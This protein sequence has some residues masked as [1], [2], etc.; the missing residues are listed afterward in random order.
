LSLTPPE[1]PFVLGAS[2]IGASHT[3]LGL[4]CQD[5]CA[6]EILASRHCLA[7]VC[8]GLGSAA[9]SDLGA[10]TAVQAALGAV[11]TRLA[12]A[13]PLI[14]IVSEAVT[15]ARAAL[16][17]LAA[18]EECPLR[19][20]ACTIL[21]LVATAEEIATAHIGDGAMVMLTGGG[22]E[23]ASA[24]GESEYANEVV[25]LTSPGWREALRTGARAVDVRGVALFSDGLQRIALCKTATG[26]EPHDGFLDPVFSYAAELGDLEEGTA[27][28]RGLLASPKLAAVS[29][30]DK[31]LVIGILGPLEPR[32]P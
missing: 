15:A 11:K 16:E 6:F 21:V 9:R 30:D 18:R 20:L 23:I 26:Y 29:E 1:A 31:T 25:P 17:D 13:A 12:D 4:P 14:D 19:D 3:T 5:A 22:L 28:I 10:G 27:E 7:V 32:R 8:D 24:P 2:V